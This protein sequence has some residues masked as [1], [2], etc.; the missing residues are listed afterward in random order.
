MV[1]FILAKYDNALYKLKIYEEEENSQIESEIENNKTR[2]VCKSN[3]RNR[4]SEYE[5]SSESSEDDLLP[6]KIPQ[7]EKFVSVQ[8]I[9]FSDS[10][11]R[12]L[13]K[14]K[15]FDNNMNEKQELTLNKRVFKRGIQTTEKNSQLGVIN[16]KYLNQ[17]MEARLK[18]NINTDSNMSF[19]SSTSASNSRSNCYT[20]K[21]NEG[22]FLLFSHA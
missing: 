20:C 11:G 3:V 7:P 14:E 6:P 19:D 13:Q 2:R 12:G 5:Y 15:G 9:S 21:S 8:D 10:A 4:K 22:K 17:P 18:S 1:I 16:H